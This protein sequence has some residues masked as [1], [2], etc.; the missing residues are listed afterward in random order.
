MNIFVTSDNPVDC[1]EFLD[2]KRVIKMATETAQLLSTA[3]NLAGG[4]GCYKTT[5]PNHPCSVWAR[6][7]QTN[8]LWL[9]IHGLALC[10]E[11]TRRYDK[12]HKCQQ[13]ISDMFSQVS[14]LPPGDL[15]PFVNCTTNKEHK[16]DYRHISDV[17]MAYQLYLND[18]WDTDKREP[19]WEAAV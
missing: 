5:H 15:T 7:T 13:L 19:T 16:I 2:N 17:H 9:F 1:A 10:Y 11:Y 8:W 14:I 12:E 4:K 18:R 6:E 3:L